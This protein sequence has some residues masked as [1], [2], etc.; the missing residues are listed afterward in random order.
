LV[1]AGVLDTTGAT[2]TYSPTATASVA[3]IPY[4]NLSFGGTGTSTLP[5]GTLQISGNLAVGGGATTPKVTAVTNNTTVIVDGNLSVA[6]GARLLASASGTISVA[7]N[8]TNA[9]TFVH[10]LG[11]V[12]FIGGG[13]KTVDPG[14]SAFGTIN[15]SD[16]AGTWT[17]LQNATATNF[18][19][20]SSTSWTLA[21]GKTLEDVDRLDVVSQHRH[22]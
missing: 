13:V 19:I 16:T 18:L 15:F 1:V 3:N 2:V 20:G 10:S 7:G 6:S 11:T 5:V 21:S 22:T 4:F 9:G 14:T 17:L 12:N 8:W